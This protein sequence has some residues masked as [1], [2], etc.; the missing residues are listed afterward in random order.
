MKS[1]F[2]SIIGKA[3]VGKST[4]LNK[5]LKQKVS[6]VSPKPQTTRNKIIGILNG[7]NYQVVFLDTP[8]MHPIKNNLDKFMSKQITQAMEGVDLILYVLDGLKPFLDDEI[9]LISSYANSPTPVILVVNKIDESTMEQLYPKLAKL[10]ILDK[11]KEIIP[12]SAKTGKNTDILIEKILEN[13]PEGVCFYPQ[14]EAT[15]KTERFIAGEIIREKALWLLN[16]EIPHGIAVIID[17]FRELDNITR[18]EATL[19]CEKESHKQII[20]GKAGA[21]LKEISTKS[22]LE[23]EEQFGRKV[24]LSVWVKVKEKWR[25]SDSLIAN[26]GY[27]EKDE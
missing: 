11:V 13:L 12:L 18:I 10:N 14:D 6:I 15:D 2:V 4:L 24:Y 25:D 5:L 17:E 21:M 26:L 3:N 19:V 27:N 9:E 22:R 23:M 8:G 16:D 1:G 20:I 7:E